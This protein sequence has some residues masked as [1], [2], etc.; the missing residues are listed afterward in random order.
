MYDSAGIEWPEV[1][2]ELTLSE[3]DLKHPTLAELGFKFK[4]V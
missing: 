4:E 1:D 2:T 3:K